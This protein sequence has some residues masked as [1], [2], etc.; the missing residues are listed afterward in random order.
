M[1][2]WFLKIFGSHNDNAIKKYEKVVK[3][4]NNL[5]DEISI[6][7]DS[8]L[9]QKTIEFRKRLSDGES[10]DSILPEAFA[11]V[12]EAS[13][14]VLG[15]RHFNS[16][17]IGGMVLHDGRI[18]EMKTGEGKTLVA[19]LAVYLNALPGKGVHVVTV[20][21]YLAK[22]D[23][24]W[25][26]K[27]Y[28]FL[29][30]SVG[31][32]VGGM[33]DE[34]KKAAYACDIVYGTNHEFGFDYLRDNLKFDES[35]MVL[36]PFHFAVIDEVDSILIDEAR[37]PLVI[38]GSD[39]SASN[40]YMLVDEAIKNIE[41]DDFEKDEKNRVVTLTEKGVVTV[42]KKLNEMGVLATQ[43]LY[44]IGN[45]SVV[46]H[47]NCA[48][49]A[50]QLFTKDVDY[51]VRGGQ[52]MIIDEFTGRLMEGRRYSEG[53]HQ[54][55]E[56][57][58]GVEVQTES[59][60]VATISYQNLFRLYPKIS[61]MTGTAMTEEAEFEEIY[62]L[63]VLSIPSNKPIIRKDHDDS[64]FLTAAEKEKAVV[65]L[66]KE[67]V[68]RKQPVLVG[69]TSLERSEY[70]S[71]LLLR[72][73]I[74]HNVLNAKHHEKEAYVIS[75]AG[76]PG[77]VTIATNM[78][79]RG[80]DIKLGGSFEMRA[81]IECAGIT[82]ENLLQSKIDE[83][84]NDIAK[85]QEIVVKAGGLFVIGTERNE[86]RR[87]DNQLRG[88]SGRQGDPGASK[89]FLS[90]EDDLI[91]RFGSPNFAKTLQKMGVQKN[92]DLTH[93]WISKAIE[94][95]QQRVE[96]YNF[97]IRK[98]LLRFDDVM[99]EQRKIVYDQ[100][101]EIINATDIGYLIKNMITE[102]VDGA[103]AELAQDGEIVS[104][105]ERNF[106]CINELC[107]SVFNTYIDI[108]LLQKEFSVS[109]EN[110]KDFVEKKIL[111]IYNAKISDFGSDLV[112]KI[113]KE[114]ALRT[115]DKTWRNH[116]V[117][118]EHLRRGVNLAAYAQKNPLNEY[119]FEAF[120]L[121]QNMLGN[122]RVGILTDI[123]HYNFEFAKKSYDSVVGQNEFDELLKAVSQNLK[124]KKTN[125][126]ESEEAANRNAVCHCGSG[127]RYKHCHGRL[128]QVSFAPKKDDEVRQ[129]QEE[130]DWAESLQRAC[131][132]KNNNKNQQQ[133][134]GDF[135]DVEHYEGDEESVLGEFDAAHIR[136]T[137]DKNQ[138]EDSRVKNT[139]I[140]SVLDGVD[141]SDLIDMTKVG[142]DNI[143]EYLASDNDSETETA[144]HVNHNLE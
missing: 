71:K 106:D 24:S 40:L 109:L 66:V 115:L 68:E 143:K 84:K 129:K 137:G 134:D 144:R 75:E 42:E 47:V 58:E 123:F 125:Q 72:E 33:S 102:A 57:K 44:D 99:N 51:M 91:R 140:S 78:A 67:C 65:T 34:Q 39:N 110:L 87:I 100:R 136:L 59:Q 130:E 9:K 92:E 121:F 101:K 5:E 28:K 6:L 135:D 8:E 120:N 74:K 81:E 43:G 86:S 45:I 41:A 132:K 107:S 73:G 50:H 48:L 3:L 83:I 97:D 7:S 112:G 22:R 117:L 53:L 108:A 127:K 52:V 13:N 25:M 37:T 76:T 14:R 60:T 35:E 96:A 95:A 36:R 56:A 80:T 69:T 88:R 116:L 85:K 111:N 118:L 16:Q 89:Y 139:D 114:I 23:A 4:I 103:V 12:R 98:Q 29:G 133:V 131:Q 119:K 138:Q 61:G 64:I 104:D 90:L 21:D 77:T 54:A 63:K 32:S 10:L 141:I 79:G 1:L 31:T 55:I 124:N 113:E 128:N 30:L 46:Y 142:S 82:D 18:A 26:G 126:N 27:L 19:T 38:S 17:L 20:N 93:R 62:K 11:V 2:S 122:V 94:K 70:M 105:E 15:M 49:K